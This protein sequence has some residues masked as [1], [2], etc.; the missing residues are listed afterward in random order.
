MSADILHITNGDST[1]NYLKK[2]KF[3]GNFITW[4]E[5]LC[6]GKTT[7]DVGSESFWKDRFHFLKSSYKVSKKMFIDFT[8]KEYRNLCSQKESK[9]I[10][11]WFEY[12]LFCQIN[13]IAVLSWLKKH[14]NGHQISL[15]CSGKVE[16]SKE[17]KAIGELNEQQIHHHYD[18]R[19]ELSQE[20]IEYAD[21]IWQLYCSNSPLRLETICTF[22][23]NST[24]KYLTSA[25]QAHFMR[26]PSIK[27]GLNMVENTIL[28]TA[29]TKQISSKKQLVT[30]VLQNDKHYGF[31]DLQY[32]NKISRLQE[33]FSSFNP[34]KLSKTGM[35]ILENKTSF[36]GEISNENI[37]LGGTKKYSFL[38][39][40]TTQKLLQI[41]S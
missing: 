32:Q 26:F 29:Y 27:N 13:M 20:D 36:Y 31:G 41:T 9:E 3:S 15:V 28:E 34:V 5:M 18:N 19:I 33:L 1:T 17:L 16:G 25:L 21:Y 2:L 7:T 12:D 11:L 22:N 23:T 38:I 6:E 40:T 4:R 24:F 37:Y 14:R 35:S 8:L 10:V 39:D 30:E